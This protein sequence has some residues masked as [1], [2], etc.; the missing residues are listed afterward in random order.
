MAKVI[1]LAMLI[2]KKAY[3]KQVELFK[4]YFGESV[5]IAEEICI[6]YFHEFN[7]N[8]LAGN[9]LNEVQRELYYTIEDP[10]YV[11]FKAFQESALKEYEAIEGIA[12]E[13]YLDIQEDALVAYEKEQAK[14][15]FI[16]YNS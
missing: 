12:Y 5:E 7:I 11:A 1:T 2:E 4:Q 13:T 8:W 10:A 14:A 15:F 9:M 3:A 6:E 16:A